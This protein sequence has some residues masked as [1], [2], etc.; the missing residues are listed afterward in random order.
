HAA[1]GRFAT[2]YGVP[3]LQGLDGTAIPYDC[4]FVPAGPGSC[5]TGAQLAGHDPRFVSYATF[6]DPRDG[7]TSPQAPFKPYYTPPIRH[8]EGFGVQS[9][10]QL[11]LTETLQLTWI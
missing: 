3:F 8:F 6:L 10:L 7:R 2:S 9:N 1:G 5:D 4:R 11:E